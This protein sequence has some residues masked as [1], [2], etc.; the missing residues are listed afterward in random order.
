MTPAHPPDPV[1]SPEFAQ[2]LQRLAAA[3]RLQPDK[4]E[5]THESTLRALWLAATHQPMS[6]ER[7][8]HAPLSAL[9]AEG[10]RRL[11]ALL[12]Q[13]LAGRP[14]A[15]ITGF[16]HFA[17]LDLRVSPAALIPRLETELLARAAIDLAT[18]MHIPGHPLCVIDACTGSGNVA[19]ALAANVPDIRVHAADLDPD[20]L[21][22]AADNIRLHGLAD[23]VS[24]HQGDLLAPFENPAFED[25]V[26][27]IT[28]NPP[29]ISSGK[30]AAMDPEIAGHEPALA[31]DGG[32]LGVSILMRLVE[33]A[34]RLLRAG[35]WLAFEVGLGQGTAMLKRMQRT[36]LY[37][38]L[39]TIED[40]SG[41]IRTILARH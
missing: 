36:P 37:G 9:D 16:Q 11:D 29:Y 41:A 18:S 7:A 3:M 20:A 2:R 19:L 25:K 32:P 12:E 1:A 39:R 31:F 23:I 27:L 33:R 24:L 4:P 8:R 14:L 35:G 28:C 30:V 26:D 6:V 40:A 10:L 38:Q 34:P 15:H 17:G 5:E 13:R 21:A 22:L